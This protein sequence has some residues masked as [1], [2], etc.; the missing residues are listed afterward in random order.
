MACEVRLCVSLTIV[1]ALFIVTE[2]GFAMDARFKH[3]YGDKDGGSDAFSSHSFDPRLWHFFLSQ[4]NIAF[5]TSR[6]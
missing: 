4:L 3:H 6:A 1:C 5:I 2:K